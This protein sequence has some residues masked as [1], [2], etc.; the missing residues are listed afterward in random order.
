MRFVGGGVVVFGVRLFGAVFVFCPLLL[1]L[2]RFLCARVP[3]CSPRSFS[4]FGFRVSLGAW[5]P[6]PLPPPLP[7]PLGFR[8][9]EVSL[10]YP[11]LCISR[12][13]DA[14]SLFDVFV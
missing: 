13:M 11:A 10:E 1:V 6:V 4:V 9:V 12:G 2:L 5:F 7:L 14:L 3:P 8:L